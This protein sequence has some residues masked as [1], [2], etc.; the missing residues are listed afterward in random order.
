MSNEDL[1]LI[2]V[3]PGSRWPVGALR[4]TLK[5]PAWVVKFAAL[6]QLN[7]YQL[8]GLLRLLFPEVDLIQALSMEAG[9]HSH[10]LQN[11][12][13]LLGYDAM[14]YEGVNL[15][16]QDQPPS[17]EELLLAVM[18]EHLAVKVADDIAEAMDIVSNAMSSMPGKEGRLG[19]KTLLKQDRR[20]KKIGLAE[21]Q[22]VHHHKPKNLV[23]FDT[24]GSMG[25]NTV[26]RIASAVKALAVKA[27]AYLAIVSYTTTV[28]GPGEF[29]VEAVLDQAEFGGTHYETL[30]PLFDQDWGTVV[31]IAD[32]DSAWGASEPLRK[33][34][35]RIDLLLDISL[36]DKPTF[37]A[38][39]LAP[40]ADEVR[41]LMVAKSS[42]NYKY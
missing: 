22:V 7:E 28:W 42:L 23:I 12:V 19:M 16:D 8:G 32:Y 15:P 34:P 18:F 38:E 9:E 3:K 1:Q 21:M 25:E 36:V 10:S 40:L 4:R 6:Q 41:P 35:G 17:K 20:T 30:A 5:S 39:C 27:D 26:S 31:T 29:T 2:E 24:S 13:V 37:L 14:V 33:A 11:Y